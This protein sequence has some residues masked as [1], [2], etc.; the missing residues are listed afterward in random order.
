MRLVSSI[1]VLIIRLA[2]VQPLIGVKIGGND[3]VLL[4]VLKPRASRPFFETKLKIVYKLEEIW[5]NIVT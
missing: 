2:Q 3:S 1:N 5:S 4:Y